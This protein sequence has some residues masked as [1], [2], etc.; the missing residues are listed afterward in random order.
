MK[1]TSFTFA[2][3]GMSS[4]DCY[5]YTAEAAEGGTKLTLL[6]NAGNVTE[7][8]TVEEPVLERLG[9]I[10]GKYRLDLWDGFDKTKSSV[11]DGSGFTLSISLADGS[12]ISARGSNA[13]PD[14][15]QAAKDEITDVF[16]AFISW[17]SE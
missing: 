4:G 6:L 2:H 8:L 1:M 9:A 17:D 5:T 7:E 14:R 13:F 16:A 11:S 3:R 12:T 15:Y 10:A